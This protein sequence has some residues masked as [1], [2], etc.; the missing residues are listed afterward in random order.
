MIFNPA[1]PRPL[2]HQLAAQ[3]REQIRSGG[4]APGARI[5]TEAEL[6]ERHSTSRN[7]VRLALDLL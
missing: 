2:Y 3:L 4:L 7:T 5:P 6:A 1:D